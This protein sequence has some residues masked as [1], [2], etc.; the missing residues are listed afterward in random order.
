MPAGHLDHFRKLRV[1]LAA[2]ADIAG[3]D[4]VLGERRGAAR[5]FA[6]QL[7]PVEM[8][9]ADQRDRDA[10]LVQTFPDRR[11]GGGGLRGVHRDA[12]QFR[13]GT[14]QGPDLFD[15]SG[16]IGRVGVGHGLDDNGV[17]AAD[18]DTPNAGD[19]RFAAWM[20]HGRIVAPDC[21]S[22]S[23]EIP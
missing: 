16:D 1:A 7:V 11:H 10:Q 2:A 3:I 9:V 21:D 12:D 15:R 23:P 19:E 4:A 22:V 5:I 13:A 20:R 8:E 6:Q 18:A 17:G 14:G